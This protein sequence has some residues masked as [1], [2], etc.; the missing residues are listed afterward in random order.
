MNKCH[1]FIKTLIKKV[2]ANKIFLHR[3]IVDVFHD[4]GDSLL[5]PMYRLE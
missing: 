5:Y 3:G 1:S 2:L 4:N